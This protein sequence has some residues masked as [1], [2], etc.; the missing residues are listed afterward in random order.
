MFQI[1]IYSYQKKKST[2]KFL[3][4]KVFRKLKG[5]YFLFHTIIN[6][7]ARLDNTEYVK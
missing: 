4:M 1:R 2:K 5:A 3:I 7:S 6:E